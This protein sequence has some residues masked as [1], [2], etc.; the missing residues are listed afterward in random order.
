MTAVRKV[1]ALRGIHSPPRL[2]GKP[3]LLLAEGWALAADKNQWIICRRRHRNGQ[4]CWQPRSFIGSNKAVLRQVVRELGIE[5]RPEANA[6][7]HA[8]LR[9]PPHDFL[10]WRSQ[11]EGGRT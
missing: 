11:V 1:G 8:F 2:D 4:L 7:A 10:E 9:L 6:A 3:F 5:V